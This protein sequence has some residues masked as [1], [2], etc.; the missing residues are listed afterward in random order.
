MD[1]GQSLRYTGQVRMMPVF[2]HDDPQS[3]PP[4]G[5][6]D[7]VDYEYVKCGYG[8]MLWPDESSFEGYWINNMPCGV[9]IFRATGPNSE[10]T[11]EG[12]WAKDKQTN[13]S[14]FR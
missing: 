1:F 2:S 4:E 13:L 5:A 6:T 11:Y 12:F 3:R 10:R 14:V 8:K 7:V 9:G